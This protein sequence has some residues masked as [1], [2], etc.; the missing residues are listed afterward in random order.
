[1]IENNLEALVV[2][3]SV[4]QQMEPLAATG[5]VLAATGSVWQR[6][7]VFGSDWQFWKNRFFLK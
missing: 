1:M 2:F 6:L 4:W 5:S 3:G 7:A